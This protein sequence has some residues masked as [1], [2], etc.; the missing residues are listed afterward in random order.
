MNRL[1]PSGPLL[2]D[3]L[4]TFPLAPGEF[5]TILLREPYV[6]KVLSSSGV[7]A[8]YVMLPTDDT[9]NWQVGD[10]F[11]LQRLGAGSLIVQP[12]AGVTLRSPVFG[13]IGPQY[14]QAAVRKLGANEWIITGDLA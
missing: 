12:E 11:F 13:S 8:T 7:P 2:V 10:V 5:N 3:H 4:E 14:G 6:G 1:S 9:S